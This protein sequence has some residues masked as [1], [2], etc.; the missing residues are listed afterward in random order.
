MSFKIIL[1]RRVLLP[2][3]RKLSVKFKLPN[4]TTMESGG[5]GEGGGGEGSGSS[6]KREKH[7]CEFCGKKFSSGQALGGHKKHHLRIMRNNSKRTQEEEESNI[8]IKKEEHGGS[9][10]CSTSK[11]G[12]VEIDSDGKPIC[13]SVQ[14]SPRNQINSAAEIEAADALLMLSLAPRHGPKTSGYATT[15]SEKA[16]RTEIES[17][18]ISDHNS[19]EDEDIIKET[20]AKKGKEMNYISNL[21]NSEIEA[22]RNLLLLSRAG[23][24]GHGHGHEP[25]TSGYATTSSGKSIRTEIG[26]GSGSGIGPDH[27]SKE[28]E[29]ITKETCGLITTKKGKKMN[30]ISKLRNAERKPCESKCSNCGKSFRSRS[31]C[32]CKNNSKVQVAESALPDDD[33]ITAK[34]IP[35]SKPDKEAGKTGDND[36]YHPVASTETSFRCDICNKT[37]STAQGLGCHKRI[38]RKAPARPL[39]NEAA[40]AQASNKEGEEDN[41][42]LNKRYLRQEGEEDNIDLNKPYLMKEGEEDW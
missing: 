42:A 14:G 32:R 37:F 1:H 6:G 40:L 2:R 10:R 34:E 27:G 38:H 3:L 41:T 26:S 29:D 33:A 24:Y 8:K 31:P 36:S 11:A 7:V 22:A 28:D 9:K 12:D 13:Y 25:E 16:I 15:S 35:A 21:T 20:T 18:S 4:N 23:T 30:Y 17:G 19:K 39:L 5:E